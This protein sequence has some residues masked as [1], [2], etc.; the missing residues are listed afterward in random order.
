MPY[1][2]VL[3]TKGDAHRLR[4]MKLRYQRNLSVLGMEESK[5]RWRLARLNDLIAESANSERK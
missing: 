2:H 5:L 4:R 3:M 1:S